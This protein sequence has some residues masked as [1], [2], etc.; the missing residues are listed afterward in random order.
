M[1]DFREV[2]DTIIKF[3][4]SVPEERTWE[5]YD[6]FCERSGGLLTPTTSGHGGIDLIVPG[7]HKAWGLGF[8]AE[9]WGIGAEQCVAFGDNNNDVEMLRW[10]GRSFAVEDATD[11]TLAAATDTCL[12]C[13]KDGVLVA[14]EQLLG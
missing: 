6:R 1:D 4:P 14:L 9:R 5:F 2:D 8:L 3:A 13:A 11:A 12:S 10:C 7:C